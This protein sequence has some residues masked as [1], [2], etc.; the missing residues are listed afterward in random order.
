M[1]L[2][3]G[4][5]VGAAVIHVI[6]VCLFILFLLLLLFTSLFLFVCCFVFN[7]SGYPFPWKAVCD[8]NN[9]NIDRLEGS[10]K[11]KRGPLAMVLDLPF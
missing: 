6:S 9:F 10:I 2:Q 1:V 7:S 8:K 3:S 4:K 5:F 11:R